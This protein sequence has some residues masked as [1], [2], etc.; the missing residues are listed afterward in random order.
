MRWL[1]KNP[2]PLDSRLMKW[3]DYHFGR[4]VAKWLDRM[5]QVVDTDYYGQWGSRK[6]AE[7]T[8]ILRGRRPCPK[9]REGFRVIWIISHPEEVSLE[10]Y[11]SCDLVFSASRK[12]A[13]WLRSRLSIP[14]EVLLQCVDTEDFRPADRERDQP[15]SGFVFVGN[16]REQRRECAIWAIEKGLPLKVWGRGWRRWIDESYLLGEYIDNQKL[17]ALYS[18]ARATL[19][20]HWPDMRRWGFVN[21][22]VFEALAC[23]L[24]VISDHHEALDGLF[25]NAVLSYRN[26]SEF[27]SCVERL[28][29]EYPHVQKRVRDSIGMIQS[30]HSFEARVR[31]MLE[32]VQRCLG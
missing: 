21:N 8:L 1:I 18:Q 24:P 11:A 4:Y 28:L 6:K 15:R 23:G 26:R 3:G 30:E 13:E 25:G 7:V 22:R 27:D 32:T 31:V 12:H 16:T 2:A 5:G 10:E 17:P 20:D 9:R 14:V 29:L 19:N